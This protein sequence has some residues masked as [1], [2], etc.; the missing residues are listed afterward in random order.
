MKFYRCPMC[1]N[2]IA[3]LEHPGCDVMCCGKP[4]EE[5]V[6]GTTDAA[7]EKHVPVVSREGDTVTVSVGSVF[8]PMTEEH[9]IKWVVLETCCGVQKKELAPGS[10]PVVKFA[11]FPDEEV[12]SCVAY[13]NLHGLW[14]DK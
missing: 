7:V 4:M 13:C 5:I 10:D 3:Y 14:A 9:Y 8:H 6:P 11:V 12:V 2:I 1:G